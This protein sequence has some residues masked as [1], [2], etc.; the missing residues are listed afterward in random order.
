MTVIMRVTVSVFLLNM[1]EM[2]FL[3]RQLLL[4]VLNL[5]VIEVVKSGAKDRS[6]R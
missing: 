2:C 5:R 6:T 3:Y 4:C 1:G